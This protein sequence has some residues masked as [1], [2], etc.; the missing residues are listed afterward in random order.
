MIISTCNPLTLVDNTAFRKFVN[1]SEPKFAMPASA[2][3]NSLLIEEVTVLTKKLRDL[4]GWTK[5]GLTASFLG[6]S[7]FFTPHPNNQYMFCLTCI[8]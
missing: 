5:K 2:K 4:D 6:V 8:L 7:V 3:L 1:T